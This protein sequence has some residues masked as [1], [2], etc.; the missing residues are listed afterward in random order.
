MLVYFTQRDAG[1]V[2]NPRGL[3]TEGDCRYTGLYTVSTIN[4]SLIAGSQNSIADPDALSFGWVGGGGG[5]W[6]SLLKGN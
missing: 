1:E 5:G 3:G 4:V 6:G 2:R